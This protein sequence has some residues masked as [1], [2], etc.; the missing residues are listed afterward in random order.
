MKV[1]KMFPS[2]YLSK[3]DLETPEVFTI[4]SVEMDDVQTE[5]GKTEEKPIIYF[6][7]DGSKPLILNRTNAEYLAESFGQDSEE[8]GGKVIELYIDP[9]V[10]FGKKRIGGIRVRTPDTSK[11]EV[12][13]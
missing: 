5:D 10:S 3:D 13:Y 6:T 8:W 4:D 11:A 2:K 9:S 7:D 1:S 12:P